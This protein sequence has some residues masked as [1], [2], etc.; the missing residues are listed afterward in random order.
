MKLHR[1]ELTGFGPFRERQSVDFDAFD[2]DG[3]F[4]ISGRTGAGKSSILDGVSFALYGSV[5]RYD[6]GDRR[7]RSDHSFLTDPTEVRLEFTVGGTRWRVTR[8]PE[9]ERP[10]KRG[11]GLTLEPARAELEEWVDGAW[12]G[13]A[14]KQREVGLALD[15][16]L[17]LSAQQFQQV[18]LLAQNKFSRF[19]LAPNAERQQL[20]RTLFGTRRFEAYKEAL[21][22]RR[23]DA[24]KRLDESSTRVRTLLDVAER[25]HGIEFPLA[26]LFLWGTGKAPVSALESAVRVGP[27]RIDG[28]ATDHY[29][30]RQDGVD[31]QLW[32]QTGD[33]PLPRRLVITTT[34]DPARPQYASTLTWNTAPN[35]KDSTFTFTPPKDA[36]RIEL[37]EVDAVAVEEDSP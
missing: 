5:P 12:V 23:R 11:G 27:A 9:Y 33:A 20:L 13:R 15:E 18:I 7:L 30:F 22:E 24:Q 8:A 34:D 31:W 14:A 28:A 3:L 37:V 21:E 36:A 4:L 2:D 17:G 1:L 26:D 29:A 10:A 19:L 6:G 25:R 32:I 35:L 16:V